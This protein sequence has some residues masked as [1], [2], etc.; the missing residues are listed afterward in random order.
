MPLDRHAKRLLDM[1]SA[2]RGDGAADTGAGISAESLRRSMLQLADVADARSVPIGHVEDRHVQRPDGAIPIRVFTPADAG[3]EPLPCILYFHGGT[4]VF[5]SVGTHD[6]LCRM[7][8][9]A[10]GGRVISVEY[11][12]APEHPFPAAIEDGAFI[13]RWVAEHAAEL[14]VDSRRLVVAGDSAGGTIAAV[15][16]Q[17]AARD[18]G[19]HVA[20]QVLLCPVTDLAFESESRREFA[21]GYFIE[22]STL[23]WA[24]SVYCAGAELRDPRVSPLHAA[25][26]AGLPPAHIH[27][28]EFDPMRDEGRAYADALTAAGVDVRYTCHP[29]LIHHFYCMAGAI[30]QARA[31][32]SSIGAEI[33]ATLAGAA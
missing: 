21:N 30:P 12:L 28:A 1:I 16:C 24:K 31:V 32:V 2:G 22:R 15:I 29:G 9:N 4:G 26:L 5:G 25:T 14:R 6:G 8:A 13:T 3:T 27:T 18:Q 17:L 7:L 23:D 11:R 19:P 20:L 33:R 10:S